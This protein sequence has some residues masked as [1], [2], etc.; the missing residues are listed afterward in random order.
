MAIYLSA[1]NKAV[2]PRCGAR[3]NR[4]HSR[5]ER[6]VQD[7]GRKV[8]LSFCKYRCRKCNRFYTDPRVRN[9]VCGRYTNYFKSLAVEV[10]ESEGTLDRARTRLLKE[11]GVLVP[12]TSLYEWL[13]DDRYRD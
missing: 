11:T 4:V 5:C 13:G 9:V 10:Y 2:C 12:R 7:V 1:D 8:S 6:K 3:D